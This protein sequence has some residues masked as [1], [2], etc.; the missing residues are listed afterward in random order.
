MKDFYSVLGISPGAPAD[1]VK[2]AF[3]KKANQL[4]PDKNSSPE[5][6][7]RFRDVRLAYETLSDPT[8]RKAYDD[9]RQ[10]SLID[11]PEATAVEIW[12]AY[13]SGVLVE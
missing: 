9:L 4:H 3:R 12:N 7:A 6:P 5:A 10:R 8:R 2:A 11:D 13:C 1:L